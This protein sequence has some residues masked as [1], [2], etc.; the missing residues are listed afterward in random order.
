MNFRHQIL[1]I[2][3]SIITSSSNQ[4]V[5]AEIDKT[6]ADQE[7]PAIQNPVWDE[8]KLFIKDP[9][10]QQQLK[11]KDSFLKNM[12]GLIDTVKVANSKDG[13]VDRSLSNFF[14]NVF[15]GAVLRFGSEHGLILLTQ[16]K[17]PQLHELVNDVCK[18][19][20]V[21]VPVML[22]SGDKKLFNAYATSFSP[23][24]SMVVLGQGLLK[25]LSYNELKMVLAHE[26]AHVKKSHVPQ[27]ILLS[28]IGSIVIPSALIYLIKNLDDGTNT[29]A[30]R[31]NTRGGYNKLVSR[32]KSW[33]ASLFIW[34]GMGVATTVCMLLR[35]RAIEKEADMIAL[36]TLADTESF[37]SMIEKLEDKVLTNKKS[38]E[39]SYA[40][41]QGKLNEL[42]QDSPKCAWLL[43]VILSGHYN[44]RMNAYDAV[45]ENE[46]G[47][48]PSCKMRKQYAQDFEKS[49]QDIASEY[50]SEPEQP[51]QALPN[52]SQVPVDQA[53]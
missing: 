44:A 4:I 17:T 27:Q 2:V 52:Q 23:G 30:V 50:L 16:E 36:T 25:K 28:L 31:D 24:L 35:S 18:K 41:V 53:L 47:D 7:K 46:A 14:L 20:N 45:L 12:A 34:M 5:Y 19:L 8:I 43:S 10:V 42:S 6:H 40:Y 48:H 49:R 3:F 21:P 11:I 26:L 15:P 37:I 1:L 22:V 51:V 29:E 32:L 39:E 13:F 9:E 38:F 33:P